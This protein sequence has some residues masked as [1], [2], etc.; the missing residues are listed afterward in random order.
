M[1]YLYGPIYKTGVV[2]RPLSLS[3]SLS[4]PSAVDRADNSADKKKPFLRHAPFSLTLSYAEREID[5]QS[6]FASA[7]VS[8]A[9][10]RAIRFGHSV[11]AE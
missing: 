1:A 3:L 10:V 7:A 4:F 2:E 9:A 11:C 6:S 5:R 8:N